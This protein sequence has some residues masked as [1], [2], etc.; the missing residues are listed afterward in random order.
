M[1]VSSHSKVIKYLKEINFENVVCIIPSPELKNE[2]IEKLEKRFEK[3]NLNEDYFE[4]LDCKNRYNETIENI[5]NS[6]FKIV[7]IASSNY[8]LE[9]I[10]LN[11]SKMTDKKNYK[12]KR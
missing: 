5:T 9:E 4:L 3:S 12:V 6:G 1:F 8:I 2:W 7:M 10:I 11:K